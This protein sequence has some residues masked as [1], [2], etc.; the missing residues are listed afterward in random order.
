M[1]PF[2]FSKK[3]LHK[4]VKAYVIKELTSSDLKVEPKWNVW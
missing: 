3:E 4:V 2:F 1:Q